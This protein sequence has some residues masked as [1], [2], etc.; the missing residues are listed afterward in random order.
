MSLIIF[1]KFLISLLVGM[2]ALPVGILPSIFLFRDLANGTDASENAKT[3]YAWTLWGG[4]AL[5]WIIGA[6]IVWWVLGMV[7]V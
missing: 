5:A 4:M 6:F 7:W 2:L 1:T 3:R